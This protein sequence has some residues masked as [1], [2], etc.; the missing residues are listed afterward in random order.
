M[1][2]L[3]KVHACI[4]RYEMDLYRY[5]SRFLRVKKQQ[6]LM[7]KDAFEKNE[8]HHFVKKEQMESMEKEGDSLSRIRSYRL[9]KERS[10]TTVTYPE[11]NMDSPELSFH[12]TPG[13]LDE[14]KEMFMKRVFH[15]QLKW[16][17]STI[18]DR[19]FADP[20]LSDDHNLQELLQKLPDQHLIMY[21]P[22]L[23]VKN[24]SIAL[25]TILIS[26]GEITCIHFLEGGRHDVYMGSAERFWRKNPGEKDESSLLSPMISLSR[27]AAL[28]KQLLKEKEIGLKVKKALVCKEGFVEYPEAPYDLTVADKRS[29]SRWMYPHVHHSMPMKHDQLKAA[30]VLLANCVIES[31]RR[32]D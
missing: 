4:S 10:G 6:W 5:Q 27:T 18:R 30:G 1:A 28:V 15:F 29:Y 24:T 9:K 19:S 25:D 16:A 3:I 8:F 13:S 14:L 22:V 26:P 23:R 32:N 21:A 12:A 17:T 7:L 2:Q 20:S 31:F 11:A